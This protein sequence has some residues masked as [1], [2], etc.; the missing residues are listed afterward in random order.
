[1]EPKNICILTNAETDCTPLID[2]FNE[3]LSDADTIVSVKSLQGL[4]AAYERGTRMDL[5]LID[6]LH[7]DST[8]SG[9]ECIKAVRETHG[10]VP[11]VGFAATGDV[12]SASKAI[13]A[14]ASDFLVLGDNLQE[15]IET[16]LVKVDAVISL[17][18]RNRKLR[19]RNEQLSAS[20]KEKYDIFTTSKE[21]HA[22]LHQVERVASVP[23]PVFI[24]GERG[25]GKELVAQA[26]HRAGN[27]S[28]PFITVNCAAFPE[29][30][31][32]SELFGYVKGAFT[33][34]DSAKVGKFEQ[35]DGGTL[36]LDEI[37]NMSLPFQQKILRVVEYG[38][39]SRLGSTTELKTSARIIA[40]TNADLQEMMDKGEFMRDL[41]DRLSFE[42]INIPPLR[43]RKE[44]IEILSQRFLDKFMREIPAF[45]GKRMAQSAIKALKEY[46]FPGNVRE[47]K[48]IIERAA[49]RDTTNE[50]TTE[51]IGFLPEHHSMV[52]GDSFMEKV[53]NYKRI[54]I[55][56]AMSNAGNNQAKA[57]KL[58]GLGYHQ[59]RHY[60]MKVKV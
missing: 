58:L 1:M 37:G 51:D 57:A 55:E 35:A 33:G 52:T 29:N 18:H 21:M 25:T 8:V 15:R 59:F 28:A 60:L 45:Q 24:I 54:L 49:Y 41:Y 3:A 17:L 7:G 32:E 34:A 22:V 13:K 4:H 50:I 43:E 5:I 26:I 12:D 14:G 9:T 42:T 19:E 20:V 56:E 27:A 39:F 11:I 2:L 48:N 53:E 16:V 30:L 6:A 10:Q 36:F 47:L 40:A 38:V 23:R 46:S 31:L 44:D